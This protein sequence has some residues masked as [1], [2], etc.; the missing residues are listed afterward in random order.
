LRER[1]AV[2]NEYGSHQ[3][4]ESRRALKT[5]YFFARKLKLNLFI[6]LTIIKAQLKPSQY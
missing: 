6:Y 3:V 1:Q 2:Q 4:P 5:G